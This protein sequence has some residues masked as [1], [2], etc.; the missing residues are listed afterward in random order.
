MLCCHRTRRQ[1]PAGPSAAI[2]DLA[3]SQAWECD[4]DAQDV[5]MNLHARKCSVQF[6]RYLANESRSRLNSLCIGIVALQRRCSLEPRLAPQFRYSRPTRLAL[7][8]RHSQSARLTLFI[9]NHPIVRLAPVF[10]YYP[11][12][13][14]TPDSRHSPRLRIA[15][16]KRHS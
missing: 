9:R 1:A 16:I 7:T 6:H 3:C 11:K 14:L 10:R 13:R 12:A 4:L 8:R 2:V 15:L 5:A